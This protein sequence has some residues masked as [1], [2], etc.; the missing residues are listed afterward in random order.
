MRVGLTGLYCIVYLGGHSSHT[1]Q[2]MAQVKCDKVAR[3]QCIGI[4]KTYSKIA[5]LDMQL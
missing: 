1:G 2:V 3:Y 4:N 5:F